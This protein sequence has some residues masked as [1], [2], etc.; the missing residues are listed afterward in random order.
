MLYKYIYSFAVIL[1]G[2]NASALASTEAE[3][4]LVKARFNSLPTLIDKEV[5]I[6]GCGHGQ[7]NE[8][9]VPG[10]HGDHSHRDIFCVDHNPASGADLVLDVTK[11]SLEELAD[12]ADVV[13]FEYLTPKAIYDPATMAN[14]LKLLKP[15][16]H[17]LFDVYWGI[18]MPGE[19]SPEEI[20]ARAQ[21]K[22]RTEIEFLR[23]NQKFHGVFNLSPK[24]EDLHKYFYLGNNPFNG[25]LNS[26][27]FIIPA[28]ELDQTK[29]T[30]FLSI[31]QKHALQKVLNNLI[32]SLFPEGEQ[33]IDLNKLGDLIDRAYLLSQWNPEKSN[34]PYLGRRLKA[35]KTKILPAY[36]EARLTHD[37]LIEWC[38]RALCEEYDF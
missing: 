10:D 1:I 38:N 24:D 22:I 12:L 15:D 4:S 23:T 2:L 3:L 20:L 14:A 21:L 34:F 26:L 29:R 11:D 36:K 31:F 25:R 6:F 8:H 27:I 5:V 18:K 16:G 35:L 37:A 13:Y 19:P 17:L 28:N 32:N 9:G 33:Q 30:H 7:Q